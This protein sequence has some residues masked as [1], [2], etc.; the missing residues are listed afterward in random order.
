M[1]GS[2]RRKT[3]ILSDLRR[4]IAP[5]DI[6]YTIGNLIYRRSLRYTMFT[7]GI[8]LLGIAAKEFGLP[9]FTV[10]QAIALPLVIGGLSLVVGTMLKVVPS[11]IASRLL[12]VAQASDLNLMEDYRKAEA[13]EHLEALW[14]R[15]HRYEC[16]LRLAEGS[17]GCNACGREGQSD[18]DTL[19]RA[20]PCFLRRAHRALT[21]HLPQIQQM[22]LVGLDLRYIEDWRDGAY[23]DRSDT[24]LI[25]QFDGSSTLKAVRAE[26]GLVGPA[27]AVLFNPRRF[28][29]RFWF[30]FV[31]RMVAIQVG[32]AVQR[33]N[34]QFRTD[35]FNCQVLLWPGTEDSEWLAQFDGAREEVLRRRRQC[36]RRVFGQD[37][38]TACDVLDRMLYCSFALATELRMRY[39]ADYCDGSLGYDVIADLTGEGRNR[40]DLQRAKA[41]VEAAR[42]D[43]TRLGEFL[44]SRRPDLLAPAAGRALRAARIALHTDR[45]GLKRLLTRHL[46][47]RDEDSAAAVLRALD[48]A[49]AEKETYSRRLIAVRMHHELTRLSRGGYHKL[50]K[51]LAYEDQPAPQA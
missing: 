41:F 33:L 26:T 37:D 50:V 42:G 40:R 43:L 47:D 17:P 39:D 14:D 18:A 2:G 29:Q 1:N 8:A 49:V 9:G 34:R 51:A 38:G 48:Q 25:E 46:R 27:A 4:L 36:V 35:L 13:G 24:K 19:E 22:H 31:T 11:L 20:K 30:L 28:L 15:L 5:L 23:L 45:G 21:S 44:A 6:F 32:S 7:A 16:G 12:T 3:A 10:R